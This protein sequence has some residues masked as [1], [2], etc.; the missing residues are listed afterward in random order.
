MCRHVWRAAATCDARVSSIPQRALETQLH[1]PADVSTRVRAKLPGLES[2]GEHRVR[3]CQMQLS[4]A[5]ALFWVA[6]V[7]RFNGRSMTLSCRWTPAIGF[8]FWALMDHAIGSRAKNAV[9]AMPMLHTA[10]PGLH[11]GR[12]TLTSCKLCPS[13]Q[14]TADSAITVLYPTSKERT[15]HTAVGPTYSHS[16]APQSTILSQWS[17]TGHA[18][19]PFS[20]LSPDASKG[21]SKGP[22]P[23]PP[24]VSSSSL[25]A[26]QPNQPQRLRGLPSAMDAPRARFGSCAVTG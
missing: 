15:H 6:L 20:C 22:L 11:V 10:A 3:T 13:T 21:S 23:I 8:S 9:L 18:P 7:L 16:T 25:P 1:S 2:C 12:L 24:P 17:C 5:A 14:L 26:A 4:T 19:P